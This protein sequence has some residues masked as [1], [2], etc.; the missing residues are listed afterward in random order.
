MPR[1]STTLT[2]FQVAFIDAPATTITGAK[3]VIEGNQVMAHSQAGK[4]IETFVVDDLVASE[5][6]AD[7]F[8]GTIGGLPFVLRRMTRCGC[9]GTQVRA[10]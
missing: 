9:K 3:V 5:E 8:T 6:E 10:K 7:V 4:F 1:E 2:S